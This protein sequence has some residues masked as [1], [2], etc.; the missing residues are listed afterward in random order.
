MNLTDLKKI[1]VLCLVLN[2]ISPVQPTFAVEKKPEQ[3]TGQISNPIFKA[4]NIPDYKV[5]AAL[6]EKIREELRLLNRLAKRKQ[7]ANNTA[8][9][10]FRMADLYWLYERSEYFK[11][12]DDF[13][14]K[15]DLYLKKKIAKEPV[16]PKFSGERSF[17]LYKRIVK[18]APK[19]E[20]L[21][22]V[23]FLAGFHAS[24]INSKD[25][26]KYLNLLIKRFPKSK[27]ATGAYMTLGDY[28]F[29]NREFNKAINAYGVVLKSENQ[30]NTS[31]LY[32]ISWCYYNKS[33]VSGALKVMQKVVKI[34]KDKQN[35]INLR[36][37]ALK[38][39]ILFY[40]DLGLIEPARKYFVSIGEPEYARLVIEKLANI[41][42][43]KSEYNKA[44]NALQKLISLDPYHPDA[45][46]HHSKIIESYEKSEQLQ[47]AMREMQIFM[48]RY[49]PGSA[50]NRQNKG[51][52]DA[53]EYAYNRSEVYARFLSKHHHEMAQKNETANKVKA[54]NYTQLALKFYANY[55]KWFAQH[56]NGYEMRF[57]YANLLFK[58]KIYDQSAEQY[59]AML[60]AQKD[61][62][63]NQLALIG[64]IDSLSRL[65][66]AYYAGV[67]K[68]IKNKKSDTYIKTPLSNF[69]KRLI[70]ADTAYQKRYPQDERSSKVYFQIAQ[71]YYNYN[72]FDTAQK[73]FF[74]VIKRYPNSP[75]ANA[76]RH[77]ILDIYNIQKDWDNL[78]KYA[79]DY[80]RVKS[81]ATPEN[82]KLMLELI[83]GSIF[84]KAKGLEEKSK[85]I[86]AA[87][88]Y[89]S[90]A[91][92]Y[93]ESKF[94]DK[95]LYNAAIDYLNG[96]DS[97]SALKTSRRFLKDYSKSPLVPKMILALATHFDNKLDYLNASEQFEILATRFPK[98]EL[99]SAALYN[100]ALY[101]EHL[102]QYDQ[103][104]KNYTLYISRYPKSDDVHD[105]YFATGLIYEKMKDWKKASAV[106]Y[107][108]PKRYPKQKEKFAEASYRRG[109]A[110][111][112]IG[113]IN[114]RNVSYDESIKNAKRYKSGISYAAK[115]QFELTQAK[116]EEFNKIEFRMP[117][118]A[119]AASIE[120]KAKLLKELKDD[121]FSIIDLGD[122]EVG[123][124]SLYH[125][126]LIYQNFS[127][128]LFN[129]P[130]PNGL[131]MEQEQM[132]Q[133]ELQNRALPIEQK[134]IEAYEKAITKAF[135]L[136]VYNDWTVKAYDNLTQYKPD[137]YP[138]R[139][140]ESYIQ[141]FINEPLIDFDPKAGL[142]KPETK[143]VVTDRSKFLVPE[144]ARASSAESLSNQIRRSEAAINANPR[145]VTAYTR[146]A[147]IYRL[148]DLHYKA[149]QAYE[150]ASLI[151]PSD[152]NILLNLAY[153]SL[154]SNDKNALR[155]FAEVARQNKNNW[156]ITNNL[157][158]AQRKLGNKDQ[159]LTNIQGI[160]SKNKTNVHAINNLG[161]LYYETGKSELAELTFQKA[162]KYNPKNAETFN[163]LGMVYLKMGFYNS[164]IKEFNSAINLDKNLI[165]PVINLGNIYLDHANFDD[166][167]KMYQKALNIEP[168]N[169]SA[170]LNLGVALIAKNQIEQ[171]NQQF[172]EISMVNPNFAE[173]AFNL[174]L[175][176]HLKLQNKD[177]AIKN[178]KRFINLKGKTIPKTHPVYNMLRQAQSMKQPKPK[179]LGGEKK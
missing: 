76:S 1:L 106:F 84:Q 6:A 32:K 176:N 94:A 48:P 93:P 107:N 146:L 34:S 64:L 113:N 24:E 78:E 175:I 9:V 120:R 133:E 89:E 50:W 75:A 114:A 15:Y 95:A 159:A 70:A 132:Y 80:L 62:T 156:T 134:A 102:K 53:L 85:F 122:A 179:V 25:A 101:R 41:Y 178:Y 92:K 66:E 77:L 42:F 82:K 112:N 44:V 49:L 83:Q 58:N 69:A 144:Q 20:R 40:S 56:K 18:I 158:T 109:F 54:K 173:N 52:S 145:A 130:V 155:L 169:Q 7:P 87:R 153:S 164:A 67:E 68:T 43:E 57:L 103:S 13:E 2:F 28:Y 55:V 131:S 129:A 162:K 119:L 111:K 26:V 36:R 97:N 45:P 137:K 115:A 14:R 74:D 108:F 105:A 147:D 3:R 17:N 79:S 172:T 12:M 166:A 27:Y 170:K 96:N 168:M 157:I 163:N 167:I 151:R 152:R 98:S 128:A 143:S 29:N 140:G 160:M 149:K 51:R 161:L 65:E 81:F 8:E 177:E 171:A 104:L 72:Q 59:A 116:F 91:D 141:W 73:I 4:F 46:R 126:G 60:K 35:E 124:K 100:A 99:A 165:E 117:Q 88:K 86:E 136:N 30:F 118:R 38:D 174:G 148:L 61:G 138:Q 71:L 125:V 110:Q 121:Y 31:A 11:K 16:E 39:L 135:E 22:E 127:L 37:E 123:V 154:A 21:D 19:Y 5:D 47:R 10:Y 33:N 63:K 150:N 142:L 90:L 139:Q 23:L